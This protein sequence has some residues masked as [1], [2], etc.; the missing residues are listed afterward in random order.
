MGSVSRVLKVFFA[1]A[2]SSVLFLATAHAEN[3]LNRSTSNEPST[4]DPHLA[5]GNSS[6]V[7]ID[8]LFVGLM[9]TSADGEVTYGLAKSHTLDETGRVYTFSLREDA[10][11][12]DGSPITSADVVYSFRRL[13]APQTA[14]RYAGNLY[15]LKNGR[16]VNTG[17]APAES[18]GVRAPDEHTVIVE[19]EKPV[20]FFL[21]VLA[22]NAL[23]IL[24][25]QAIETHGSSW[26]RPGKIIV[27]GA[28]TL[29][30]WTPGTKITLRKNDKFWN[31]DRV[32]IDEVR[33]FP[34]QDLGT[35]IKQFRAKE[36]D[37]ALGFPP[38]QYPFLKK[39]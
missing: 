15:F 27:N 35:V 37:I 33:Y 9:T 18:L 39:K 13:M 3:I 6:S 2:V 29:K 16:A 12:S 20:P 10:L 31:A 14:A 25:R 32:A 17:Q 21:K 22:G 7:I 34:T 38:E 24:P 11:W 26:A 19:L 36:L 1:A 5:L 23:A 28:Y 30:E 4:L 8:D